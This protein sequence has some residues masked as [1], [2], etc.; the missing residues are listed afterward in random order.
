MAEYYSPR[1]KQRWCLS[2]Y[3]NVGH[4]S[5]G[6]FPQAAMVIV[7]V[8]LLKFYI[9]SFFHDLQRRTAF[10]GIHT[11]ALLVDFDSLF[12]I[13]SCSSYCFSQ[14]CLLHSMKLSLFV[15]V[16]QDAWQCDICGSKSGRGFGMSYFKLFVLSKLKVLMLGMNW[17][18]YIPLIRR[19]CT[20]RSK[21]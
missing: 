13:I 7:C 11:R 17:Y 9:L 10:H 4:H 5:L 14:R 2:L 20:Y 18:W 8:I 16:P 1:A 12:A 6:V 15:S 3:D 19:S 21:K